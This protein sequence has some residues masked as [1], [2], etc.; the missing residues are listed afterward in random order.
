[1]YWLKFHLPTSHSLGWLPSKE[2]KTNKKQKITSVGKNVKK[3][4]P[5]G[6]VGGKAK[7]C[8]CCGKQYG[9]SWKT[10]N[11]IIMWSSHSTS[12]YLPKRRQ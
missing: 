1:M 7:W 2:K 11:R 6:T 3:V 5:V 10:K 4:E 12:G 8:I 9:G